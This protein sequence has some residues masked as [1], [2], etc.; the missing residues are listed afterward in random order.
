MTISVAPPATPASAPG[1][2]SNRFRLEPAFAAVVVGTV[3]LIAIHMTYWWTERRGFPLFVDESG[4]IGFAFDHKHAFDRDGLSGLLDSFRDH[5]V[6]AQLV[7]LLT[8]P[9]LLVFGESV[10]AS[11]LVVLVFYG[12]MVVATY[13]V[14]RRIVSPW[15]SALAALVVALVP[16]VV[17]FARMYYFAIPVAAWLAIAVW[18]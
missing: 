17:T 1:S 7:P 5:P 15:W 14:A 12:V 11:Y 6:Y 13:G 18:C 16:Q 4:Y 8:V 9:F 3:V 10:T 2:T